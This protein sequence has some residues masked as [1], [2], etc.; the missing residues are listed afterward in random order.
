MLSF[1]VIVSCSIEAYLKL[2]SFCFLI[3]G[4]W[5]SAFRC[6][7]GSFLVRISQGRVY[8][9]IVI[10]FVDY[11]GMVST[12]QGDL[13]FLDFAWKVSTRLYDSN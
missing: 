7:A 13:F 9:S 4:G 5:A 3:R 6:L 12:R 2:F 10:A 1:D 11:V 8:T